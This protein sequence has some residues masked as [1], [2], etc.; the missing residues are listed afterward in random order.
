MEVASTPVRTRLLPA[1]SVATRPPIAQAEIE[2]VVCAPGRAYD[3][4]MDTALGLAV[5]PEFSPGFGL[6]QPPGGPA[7]GGIRD[8]LGAVRLPPDPFSLLDVPM[9][10]ARPSEASY[11]LAQ[12]LAVQVNGAEVLQEHL[13]SLSAAPEH[14]LRLFSET[15]GRIFFADNF[16]AAATSDEANFRRGMPLD[17]SARRDYGRWDRRPGHVFGLYDPQIHALIFTSQATP[18]NHE[19]VTL[20]ELGH[21]LTLRGAWE[22]APLRPDV[23]Q[24]LPKPIA[25][26]LDNYAQGE[27]REAVRERVLE[28]L[29]EAYAWSVL[30]R[31]RELPR[32]LLIALQQILTSG[33]LSLVRE[34]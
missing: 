18:L 32:P 6:D 21:A 14:D 12:A 10:A 34:V 27:N 28:A 26:L 33:T 20:H 22:L 8:P 31:Y 30:G 7:V 5:S 3:Y 13:R 16:V 25:L 9:D 1:R 4:L 23:L 17:A 29:A 15:R 11:R 24:G 2:P 19:R